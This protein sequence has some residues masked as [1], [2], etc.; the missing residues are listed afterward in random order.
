MLDSHNFSMDTQGTHY[1]IEAK[2]AIKEEE[3]SKEE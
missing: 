1:I 2:A 3:E